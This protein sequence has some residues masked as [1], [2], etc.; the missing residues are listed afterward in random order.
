MTWRIGI[1]LERG[2][3][4]VLPEVVV[5]EARA[6]AELEEDYTEGGEA[7][8]ALAGWRFVVG[9]FELGEDVGLA[10]EG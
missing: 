8:V 6:K 2:V 4:R 9:G 3:R 7:L 1:A 10:V 5:F